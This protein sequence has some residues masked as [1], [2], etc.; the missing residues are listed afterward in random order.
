MTAMSELLKNADGSI[1]NRPVGSVTVVRRAFP[2]L[3]QPI[4][5][6]EAGIVTAPRF[7]PVKADVPILVTLLGMFTVDNEVEYPN[8]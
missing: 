6:T 8:R 7:V 1:T 3:S 2:K 5:V 4:L